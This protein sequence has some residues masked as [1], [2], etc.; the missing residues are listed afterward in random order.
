MIPEQE[1]VL[2]PD[3]AFDLEAASAESAAFPA[4]SLDI[5]LEYFA[6]AFVLIAEWEQALVPHYPDKAFAVLIPEEYLNFFA[7][8]FQPQIPVELV[9][10]PLV[11]FEL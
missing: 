2:H 7:Q 10:N 9:R 1:S 6:A 5:D 4:A 8:N 3:K 11:P